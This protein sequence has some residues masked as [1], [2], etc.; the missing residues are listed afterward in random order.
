[1]DT[2]GRRRDVLLVAGHL[3]TAVALRAPRLDT[4]S[5]WLDDTWVALVHKVDELPVVLRMGVTAPGFC[6]LLEAVFSI[7]GSATSPRRR[8]RSRPGSQDRLWST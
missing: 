4:S 5:V 6:L 7:F 1:M 8:S 3:I 2:S